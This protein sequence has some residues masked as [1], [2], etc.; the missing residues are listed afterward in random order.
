M[1]EEK[2]PQTPKEKELDIVWLIKYC[3]AKRKWIIKVVCIV[4]VLAIIKC[5][6]TSKTFTCKAGVMP[7]TASSSNLGG[8]GSM[9]ALAGIDASSLLGGNNSSNKITPDLYSNIATSTTAMLH[10][11]NQPLTW[12]E[13]IDTVESLLSHTLYLKAHPT[14]GGIIK[15]YTLGLPGTIMR[16][17]NPPPKV[18][19]D[20]GDGEGGDA[21]KPIMLDLDMQNCA[22][23]LGNRINVEMDEEVNIVWITCTG[24]NAEQSAELTT[25]VIVY[26]QQMS[27]QFVTKNARKNLEF[28]EEQFNLAMTD[29]ADKRE[30]WFRYKDSHRYA[31]EERGSIESS[32]LYENYNLAYNL[33]TN[34]QQQVAAYKL[35]VANQTPALSIVEPVVTPLKKTSPRM[36]LHLIGGVILGGVVAI[37]WLLLVLGFKQVFKPK[38]FEEVYRQYAEEEN[39]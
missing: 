11:M 1:E 14:V 20:L 33:M 21:N 10:F 7:L 4:T 22:K 8:L 37:G 12:N 5:L 17:L 15:K 27:T 23:E 2:K 16:M 18:V 35:E 13:P 26:I 28:A 29:L 9:A 6:V 30:K 36:S 38:E 3:F 32:E 34:L 24:P 39:N 19:A 31:V 25:Y